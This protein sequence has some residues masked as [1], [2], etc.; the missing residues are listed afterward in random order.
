MKQDGLGDILAAFGEPGSGSG[1]TDPGEPK[2]GEPPSGDGDVVPGLDSLLNTQ[3]GVAEETLGT[4]TG[5]DGSNAPVGST[6]AADQSEG[7]DNA[8]TKEPQAPKTDS[9]P[10]KQEGEPKPDKALPKLSL[11]QNLGAALSEYEQYAQSHRATKGYEEMYEQFLVWARANPDGGEFQLGDQKV[12]EFDA[13]KLQE[14]TRVVE[15]RL[16]EAR[17]ERRLVEKQLQRAAQMAQN[18]AKKVAL[19]LAPELYKEGS[20]QHR[21]AIGLVGLVP[22]WA[23]QTL[24]NVPTADVLLALAVKGYLASLNGGTSSPSAASK[25]AARMPASG[26]GAIGGSTPGRSPVNG[27]MA[28]ELREQFQRTGD[29]SILAE[30]FKAELS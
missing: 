11:P 2:S 25:P 27:R 26:I 12:A 9:E 5:D 17:V 6:D 16:V 18:E 24:A 21:L 7:T 22:E 13:E 15:Q 8:K 19:R 29:S 3:G 30:L 4:P 10:K 1:V 14:A 20:L 23:R 28:K